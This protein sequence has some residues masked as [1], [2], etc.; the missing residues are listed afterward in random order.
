MST[1]H[2]EI[3]L[4]E[5]ADTKDRKFSADERINQVK[6]ILKSNI[7]AT[8]DRIKEVFSLDFLVTVEEQDNTLKFSF[9]TKDE[10][11]TSSSSMFYL[12]SCKKHGVPVTGYTSK[13]D[14]SFYVEQKNKP[15][16]SSSSSKKLELLFDDSFNLVSGILISKIGKRI[17]TDTGKKFVFD[18]TH[19]TFDHTLTIQNETVQHREIG[20]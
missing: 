6:E 13:N 19:S 9:S 10:N 18:I 4:P 15:D 1:F 16:L 12:S 8:F 2:K 7:N 17:E 3:S 20:N 5:L 14:I 11:I